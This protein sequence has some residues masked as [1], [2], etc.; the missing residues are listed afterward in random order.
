MFAVR[1]G[2]FAGEKVAFEAISGDVLKFKHNEM[3]STKSVPVNQ[4]R[5]KFYQ[6]EICQILPCRKPFPNLKP[7][8]LL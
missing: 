1:H 7:C 4:L 3:K 8:L 5:L 2:S 6:N